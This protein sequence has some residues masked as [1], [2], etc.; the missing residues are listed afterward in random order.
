[1]L[2]SATRGSHQAR[3]HLLLASVVE[4][5]GVQGVQ[6]PD[7]GGAEAGTAAGGAGPSNGVGP[8]PV[9]GQAAAAQ[10][11]TAPQSEQQVCAATEPPEAG[12][13]GLAALGAAGGSQLGASSFGVG[14]K[15]E[16]FRIRYMTIG[17]VDG[18]G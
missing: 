1:M 7:D 9:V 8:A 11:G 5:E 18:F 4:D 17:P 16:R 6:K 15:G 14:S 12:T 3:K 13:T 10:A 2:A